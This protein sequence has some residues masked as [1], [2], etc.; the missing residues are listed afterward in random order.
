MRI[1]QNDIV[2]Y[3]FDREADMLIAKTKDGEELKIARKTLN[4]IAGLLKNP[5]FVAGKLPVKFG[6]MDPHGGCR[7][8]SR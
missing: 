1:K 5:K 3:G 4:F 2:E 6:K 8:C 7:G